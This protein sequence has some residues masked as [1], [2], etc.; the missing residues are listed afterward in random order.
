MQ[1]CKAGSVSTMLSTRES[2]LGG[3]WGSESCAHSRSKEMKKLGFE[4]TPDFEVEASSMETSLTTM[5]MM[6]GNDPHEYG[7]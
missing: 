6:Y 7:K 5:I 2:G 4:P 1:I 3:R